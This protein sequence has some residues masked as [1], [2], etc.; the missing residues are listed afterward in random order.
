MTFLFYVPKNFSNKI[1][2]RLLI[3]DFAFEI[4]NGHWW[5]INFTSLERVVGGLWF[6]SLQY[7][8]I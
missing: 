5:Y 3:V 6:G 8:M 4:I 7:I 2:F 1:N